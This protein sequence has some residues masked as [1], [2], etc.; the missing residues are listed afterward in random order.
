MAYA[1]GLP[2]ARRKEVQ[3]PHACGIAERLEQVGSRFRFGVGQDLRAQRG[4]AI[5]RVEQRFGQRGCRTR[6]DECECIE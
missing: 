1:D 3:D 6:I 2:V 5:D 4:T